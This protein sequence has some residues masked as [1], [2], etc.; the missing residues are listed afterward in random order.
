MC[1]LMSAKGGISVMSD[2]LKV[3][4]S[5][6]YVCSE[7][8]FREWEDFLD[9]LFD[10][11]GRVKEILWFEYVQID[12]QKESLGCGGYLDH[13]NPDFMWAETMIHDQNLENKS[14]STI[15]EHINDVKCAHLPHTLVPCFLEIEV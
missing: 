7:L 12:R 5:N 1:S 13:Q 6:N 10:S 14:L 8:I 3:Y 15:K 2:A 4:I 11:G 9:I